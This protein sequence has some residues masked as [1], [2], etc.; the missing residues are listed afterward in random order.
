MSPIPVNF[1]LN[2]NCR[3]IVLRFSVRVKHS[4]FGFLQ[5]VFMQ[6]GAS[7]LQVFVDFL[8]II[9]GVS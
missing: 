5:L 1:N 7:F 8:F 2:A 4:E 6:K 3:P 9:T